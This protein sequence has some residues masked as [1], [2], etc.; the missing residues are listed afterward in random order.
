MSK[1]FLTQFLT[2]V[3][4]FFSSNLPLN[5]NV[6]N[7]NYSLLTTDWKAIQSEIERYHLN[8]KMQQSLN[9]LFDL[10]QEFNF[11]LK[12]SGRSYSNSTFNLSDK[13]MAIQNL[14]KSIKTP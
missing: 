10:A 8:N 14:A 1:E 3:I 11:L 2:N 13:W 9:Q 7:A 5:E 12:S 6:Y 4:N